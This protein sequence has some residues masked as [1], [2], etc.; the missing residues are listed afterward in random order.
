MGLGEQ[1]LRADFVITRYNAD[2]Q[3]AMHIGSEDDFVDTILIN[4][5]EWYR[6]L[7]TF[8]HDE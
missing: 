8:T 4:Y 1:V 2:A 3:A 6:L 5:D 7:I